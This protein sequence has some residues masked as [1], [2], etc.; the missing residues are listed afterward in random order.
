MSAGV[1]AGPGPLERRYRALL[2]VLPAGYR[3]AWEDDMVATFLAGMRT[4]DPEQDA[5]TDDIGRPGWGEVASVLG[6]AVRLRVPGLPTG[7]PVLDGRPA[8]RQWNG[9]LRLVALTGLLVS[10]VGAASTIGVH[11]LAS[12]RL[13]WLPWP[14]ADLRYAPLPGLWQ[15]LRLSAGVACAAAFV[16]LL[17]GQW[18]PARAVA[19]LALLLDGCAS[20]GATVEVLSGAPLDLATIWFAVLP[21]AVVVVAIAAFAASMPPPRPRPW[22]VGLVAGIAVTSL[23][24]LASFWIDP[25]LP[26]L[27]WP[28]VSAAALVVAAGIHLAVPAQRRGP[29]APSRTLALAVLVAV[30]LAGRLVSM[31]HLAFAGAAP[32]RVP[33]LLVDTAEALVL[34]AVGLSLVRLARA[35]ARAWP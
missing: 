10:T 9:A 34:L 6:L 28:G 5:L 16:A 22:L 14:P 31:P 32:W 30:G 33:L 4:G 20:V 11:L 7:I 13:Q 29:G 26:L 8:H 15:Q 18:R 12:A 25:G 24:Q 23:L 35:A 17:L 2:R 1:D 19:V 3:A 21:D 27:D